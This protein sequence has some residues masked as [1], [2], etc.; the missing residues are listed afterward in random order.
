MT[1]SRHSVAMAVV[2]V[3]VILGSSWDVLFLISFRYR[4]GA[5]LGQQFPSLGLCSLAAA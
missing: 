2:F 5:F 3:A 1:Y 4:R